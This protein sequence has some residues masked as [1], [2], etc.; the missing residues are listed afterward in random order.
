MWR[1]LLESSRRLVWQMIS[2][3]HTAATQRTQHSLINNYDIRLIRAT[4]CLYSK[5]GKPA[6][7]NNV[8]YI[9]LDMPWWQHDQHIY[10][11]RFPSAQHIF[12]T[13]NCGCVGI[14]CQFHGLLKIQAKKRVVYLNY[15]EGFIIGNK[16]TGLPYHTKIIWFERS[17][18]STYSRVDMYKLKSLTNHTV[19]IRGQF[20]CVHWQN[21]IF[22]H[23][24][25]Y[26][27]NVC[28]N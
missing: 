4:I 19:A 10:S 21:K 11:C 1:A 24:E 25:N 14:C 23:K 2:G 13:F 28:K 8:L 7:T 16:H 3:Y 6:R 17:N 20:I 5:F 22:G 15:D 9:R 18:Q 27:V 26:F 12:F